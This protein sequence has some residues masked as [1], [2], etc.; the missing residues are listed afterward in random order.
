MDTG[1]PESSGIEDN[2]PLGKRPDPG[3]SALGR[4]GEIFGHGFALG[5]FD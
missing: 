5:P 2:F 3:W 4:S 1:P